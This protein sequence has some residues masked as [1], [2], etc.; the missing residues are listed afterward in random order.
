MSIQSLG[1]AIGDSLGSSLT[2]RVSGAGGVRSA[3]SLKSAGRIT[4]LLQTM[5]PTGYAKL[6][7]ERLAMT[8]LGAKPETGA[9]QNGYRQEM[10]LLE[11]RRLLDR[12]SRP[13]L[14]LSDSGDGSYS[15]LEPMLAERRPSG[16]EADGEDELQQQEE[17]GEA[18]TVLDILP[19]ES[20]L[21]MALQILVPFLLAGFGT[22]SAGMVL[23]VVQHWEA[24][25]Y[26]TEIFILVPALLGLKGNLEMTLASRLSTAVNVGKMDSPIEKWNL[27]IGN[28]AL[29]QVQATVV[30]FLAAV[31]AVVL[32]WI[33]EGKFQM[34]HAVLLCSSSVA[35]AFIASM[36]QG[37]IMVGV[38][39]GSKKTGIN[40]DNV[41]TP[42]AAS[43]GDLIT[44]AIL[45]WISQGLYKC[46]DSYPY[47]S[48]V[49]C[50]FFMCLTPLWMVISSKHP[51]SRTLL[52]SGW[53]PVITAMVISSIGGLILD[54]TVSDPNLAGIVVYTPVI[55]GIGGNLVAIQSSRISTFLHFHCAPGEVPDEAKG[56]YYPCRT[57]SGTG[58]N[59]RSAQ[60]LLLLVIPGHLIFL[61]TIHLMKSG[62]TT[63]TPIFMSVYLAAALLQVLLLLSI[64][65]WMVHSMWRSGKDPDSF[66]IPYLTALGDLLGTALLALSFHFLW[67]IGDRDSDV[68]D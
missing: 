52:Y 8:D 1:G 40:P 3:L 17:E 35:T 67:M 65:D 9:L 63:L 26:I 61:Y 23:D 59:H 4:S 56:C 19:K 64:A 16:D 48:S 50:A 49:V 2:V 31:A 10:P 20:P 12:A 46:L 55:N 18:Q 21:A 58:A 13:S 30:G 14:T 33:P 66:S 45:A 22:V 29:K 51:A 44:L 15:E 54:K 25:Q 36:L 11:G 60:V 27:I 6:Q 43:F 32:G 42:I 53:E 34:S 39:V 37:F 28:L 57:F 41:A 38:I 24:F 62:H 68:G 47:V 5:V 7:E